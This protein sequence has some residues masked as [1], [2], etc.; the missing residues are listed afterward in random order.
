MCISNITC[1]YAVSAI[2]KVGLCVCK[3][4]YI[5]TGSSWDDYHWIFHSDLYTHCDTMFGFPSWDWWP[6][7]IQYPKAI[8]HGNGVNEPLQMNVQTWQWRKPKTMCRWYSHMYPLVV[9]LW[10]III[11]SWENSLFSW[12]CSI[13]MLVPFPEVIHMFQSSK[14]HPSWSHDLFIQAWAHHLHW[15]A[16]GSQEFFDAKQRWGIVKSATQ[17]AAFSDA[18]V[19][20]VPIVPYFSMAIK[21]A[22]SE[23]RPLLFRSHW[24]TK[25]KKT[26]TGHALDHDAAGNVYGSGR[27]EHSR[28]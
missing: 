18:G 21:S 8:N 26:H 14:L 17:N 13:A 25:P 23:N 10:K 11:F 2:V 1:I 19:L 5:Y 16:F 27:R 3:Y 22:L 28:A 15:F 6:Q 7:P 4:I 24:W 12:P 9:K 20:I